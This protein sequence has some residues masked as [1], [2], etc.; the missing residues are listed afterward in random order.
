MEELSNF[1]IIFYL[2]MVL[3]TIGEMRFMFKNQSATKWHKTQ[4]E[5]FKLDADLEDRGSVATELNYKYLV[6]GIEYHSNQ[7]AYG[8]LNFL[9]IIFRRFYIKQDEL[10]V[11]YNPENPKMAVLVPGIRIF[12]IANLVI[13]I[14]LIWAVAGGLDL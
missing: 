9:F 1:E 6:N 8:T 7:I 4:G 5:L 2:I 12:H 14:G 13:N 3:V 10:T 11:Y